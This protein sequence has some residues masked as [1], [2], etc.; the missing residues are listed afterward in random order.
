MR[1]RLR[2]AGLVL[3]MTVGLSW[4]VAA[5]AVNPVLAQDQGPITPPAKTAPASSS[6]S[7]YVV[8]ALAVILLFGGALYAVCRTSHRV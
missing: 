6:D 7:N 5:E 4:A 3:L 8:P 1:K 2:R